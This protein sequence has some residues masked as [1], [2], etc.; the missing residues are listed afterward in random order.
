M[1]LLKEFPFS[2]INNCNRLKAKFVPFKRAIQVINIPR[3]WEVIESFYSNVLEHSG[4]ISSQSSYKLITNDRI[5]HFLGWFLFRHFKSNSCMTNQW[6]LIFSNL[7]IMGTSMISEQ[8]ECWSC[9]QLKLL[10]E[11]ALVTWCFENVWQ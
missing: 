2:L 6:S 7:Y 9:W 10:F 11:L 5:H 8:L 3:I 1:P 4:C